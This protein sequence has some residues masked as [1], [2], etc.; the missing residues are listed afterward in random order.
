MHDDHLTAESLR[1]LLEEDS[2]PEH[3]QLLLHHLAVCP[4]CY[5]V[6]GYILDLY[7]AGA[8]P[9]HFCTVDIDLARSRTE[10]P[11]L[12]AALERYSF[13]QELCLVRDIPRF[14]SWGL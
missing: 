9:L 1:T 2:T 12:F 11:G 6:G 8:L 7:K 3:N 10:A 14:K 5:A 13:S 4:A